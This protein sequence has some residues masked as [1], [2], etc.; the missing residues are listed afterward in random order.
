MFVTVTFRY[1]LSLSLHIPSPLCGTTCDMAFSFIRF[2]LHTQWHRYTLGRTS[3]GEWSVRHRDLYLT[4]RSTHKRRTSMLPAA[5]LRHSAPSYWDRHYS[6]FRRVKSDYYRPVNINVRHWPALKH[7]YINPFFIFLSYSD[8]FL[9]T[10][11]RCRGLFLHLIT[12]N[13]T[14]T[15]GGHTLDER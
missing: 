10:H 9:A 2:L 13:K 15:L 5:D 6:L 8:L 12:L 11:C 14:H 1:P 4:A 7:A 3:L